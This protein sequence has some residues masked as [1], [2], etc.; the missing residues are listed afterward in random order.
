MRVTTK[1]QVTIPARVRE[2]LGIAPHTD[3]DFLIRDGRVVLLKTDE[4]P[5]AE[6]SRF[7]SMRGVFRGKLT[8]SDWMKA[9]RGD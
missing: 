8:T 9:T 3:V 5:A 6:R 4:V 1:G 2:Y 7:A